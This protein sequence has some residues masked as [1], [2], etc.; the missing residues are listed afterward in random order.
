MQRPLHRP[1]HHSL[2]QHRHR[3]TACRIIAHQA[4]PSNKSSDSQQHFSS[5]QR[6][7]ILYDGICNLCNGGVQFMLD[8]D[9]QGKCRFA[10]LQSTA[11]RNLLQRSGRSPDDLSSIV[12]V[13]PT[14][15]YIKSEA[16]LRIA[17]ELEP[18]FPLLAATAQR[19]VP[20]PLRDWVYD[21]I[22]NNRYSFF[23]KAQECRLGWGDDGCAD[24]FIT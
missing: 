22:A 15:S 12:F 9:K 17:L 4:T 5:D 14:T 18:P 23:G 13:T 24:R 11:G 16:I 2:H 6:P 8:W 21:R 20:L 10:A 7:I 1:L 19:L 3:T